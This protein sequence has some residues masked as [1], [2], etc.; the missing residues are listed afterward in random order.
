MRLT[1]LVAGALALTLLAACGDSDDTSDT[2][3]A[4]DDTSVDVTDG[5]TPP[6]NKPEVVI[7]DEIPTELVVTDLGVGEGPEAAEGDTVVVDYVGV[8]SK[9]G[10]EFDNSYDRGQAFPVVLGSG[11]VIPGWEEGL[12]GVQ[13][14]GRRQ[15]DIPAELA[16]GDTPPA[17][18]PIAAG[19]ALTFVVDVRAVVPATDPADKPEIAVESADNVDE[20]VSEDLVEGEGATLEPGQSAVIHLI[21]YRADTGE[22]IFSS[23]EDGET[24]AF[25][26]GDGQTLPGL[27]AAVEGMNVGGRRQVQVPFEQAFGAAGNEQIGAPAATDLVLVIDLIAAY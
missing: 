23:W 12:L 5:T 26:P 22:E 16:Y 3:T 1:P 14:G 18:S 9:D 17:G 15:L 7:P 6:S 11:Q 27:E 24:L 25:R 13:A 8:L 19:D 2:T 4:T 20:A 21:A 10:T